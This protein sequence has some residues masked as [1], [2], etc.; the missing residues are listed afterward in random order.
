MST[1][2]N[3]YSDSIA[4]YVNQ[5]ASAREPAVL[6]RL[7]A[8]TSKLPMAQMQISVEQGELLALLVQTLGARRT[9]EVGVFTG[10]SSIAVARVLPHGG[11]LV[12]CDVSE[13]WTAVARQYWEEAG[14]ADRIDLRLGPAAQTLDELIAAG[15]GASYDFAFIDA[16]KRGYPGYY[17]QCMELVRPGGLIALDNAFLD[18]EVVEPSEDGGAGQ[19][20]RALTERIFADE[21]VDPALVPISDGLLLA[22]R[23]PGR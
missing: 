19:I 23:R 12:A 21:R 2:T 22:R 15:E 10:Y 17:S 11:R 3:V 9:L 6:A 7:R 20:V 8:A 1:R 14:V 5:I 18:G 16:D 4:S 13:E